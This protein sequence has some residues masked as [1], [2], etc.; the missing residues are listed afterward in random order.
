MKRLLIIKIFSLI[1]FNVLLS[2]QLFIGKYLG[3]EDSVKSYYD[4]KGNLIY[5]K[6]KVV[7][8]DL[9]IKGMAI[10]TI[11][12]ELNYNNLIFEV[13]NER[14][15]NNFI[16]VQVI[17]EMEFKWS[18]EYKMFNIFPSTDLNEIKGWVSL[19]I[20]NF[21][22]IPS[23]ILIY[24]FGIRKNE[25][26][27]N[28]IIKNC[29]YLESNNY[30]KYEYIK[31]S[32]AECLL[33][34]GEIFYEKDSIYKSLRYI[35]KSINISVQQESFTLRA[36]CKYK[37]EDYQGSIEDA[38]KSLTFF[39]KNEEQKRKFDYSGYQSSRSLIYMSDR[40]YGLKG[41]SYY[42]LKDYNSSL[43]NIN[44]AVKIYPEE[45]IYYFY[46]GACEYNI[47]K[48][49]ESCLDFSKS[50]EL[51]YFDAYNIIKEYCNKNP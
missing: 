9:P 45:G 43:I 47:G 31:E 29:E 17:G 22:P 42:N 1:S 25:N 37:M 38:N 5:L 32:H 19:D 30:K 15:V 27:L 46:K 26:K 28:Q 40:M 50:G 20:L 14:P 51:G 35:T 49:K 18:E 36:L 12:Y 3:I 4:T 16:K 8:Y 48:K 44:K 7:V 34:L 23:H 6:N 39:S 13:L 10:D 41:I 33:S 2:Q 11:K 21:H 24:G